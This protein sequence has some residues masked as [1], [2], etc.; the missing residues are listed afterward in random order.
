[1]VSD[2][3]VVLLLAARPCNAL[4]SAGRRAQ[5]VSSVSTMRQGASAVSR[6][7]QDDAD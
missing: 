7:E 4:E 1:M 2:K 5:D 3:G 6:R